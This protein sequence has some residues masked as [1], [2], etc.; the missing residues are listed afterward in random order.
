[1]LLTLL[2]GRLALRP[3]LCWKV[4]LR[5]LFPHMLLVLCVCSWWL[6]RAAAELTHKSIREQ[7]VPRIDTRR[8]RFP[9]SAPVHVDNRAATMPGTSAVA[10]DW[11]HKL[12]HRGSCQVG[13]DVTA[14]KQT[15]TKLYANGECQGPDLDSEGRHKP[16]RGQGWDAVLMPNTSAKCNSQSRAPF[17]ETKRHFKQNCRLPE[18]PR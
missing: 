9:S 3:S 5:R 4:R 11:H 7:G 8:S 18:H 17:D 6:V 16:I 10:Q 1:M 14:T 2:V 15:R 12:A 13:T